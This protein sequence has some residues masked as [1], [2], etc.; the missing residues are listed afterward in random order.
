MNLNRCCAALLLTLCAQVSAQTTPP[1]S[2]SPSP[3]PPTPAVSAPSSAPVTPVTPAAPLTPP[4]PPVAPLVSRLYAGASAAPS[5]GGGGTAYGIVVGSSQVFGPF[6]AQVAV[7]FVTASGAVSVDAALLYRLKLSGKF[8]PY[9][10]G[11]LGLTSSAVAATGTPQTGTSTTATAT[12][13]AAHLVV[14]GDYLL[15]D[16]IALN[17][18]ANYRAPFSSKGSANGAGVR[19][20]LGVKFLF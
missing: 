19:G 5:L 8:Q 14:G 7:D 17:A 1:T 4:T 9:A 6:G 20:R 2:D 15:T 3:T 11:G 13:Y 16:S 18:E 10:G 12:D